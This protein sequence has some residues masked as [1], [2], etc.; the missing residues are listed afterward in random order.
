MGDPEPIGTES[1]EAGKGTAAARHGRLRLVGIA[2]LCAVIGLGTWQLVE[3]HNQ[4][5]TLQTQNRIQQAQLHTLKSSSTGAAT[6]S[7]F[8]QL[9]QR[10]TSFR[11]R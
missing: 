8:F 7:D 5:S 4:V 1:N 9:K 2:L 10:S 11:R 3:L 6:F